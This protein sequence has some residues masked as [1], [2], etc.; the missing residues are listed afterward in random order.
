MGT[1]VFPPA[2]K[3]FGVRLVALLSLLAELACL[4]LCVVAV[5]LPGSPYDPLGTRPPSLANCSEPAPDAY[6]F[7][8]AAT[9]TATATTRAPESSTPKPYA[10]QS[11]S[12]SAS[13]SPSP[14]GGTVQEAAAAGASCSHASIAVLLVGVVLSRAGLYAADLAISQ[15]QLETVPEDERGVH[16]RSAL[17]CCAARFSICHVHL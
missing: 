14:G 12:P 4:V 8:T 1:F 6:S 13:A 15:I 11:Q 16:V 7:A 2:R 3:L 17:L 9:A 10:L 5:F